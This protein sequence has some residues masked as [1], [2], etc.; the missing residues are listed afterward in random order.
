MRP[1][2]GSSTPPL[3]VAGALSFICPL[4]NP[5]TNRWRRRNYLA[6]KIIVRG[7]RE[8]NLK[9]VNVEIP[10][11]KL[12]VVTGLSGS[13]KSSL[14]FDTIYAEGQR[15]YVE[16]LSAYARQFLGQMK[17]PD[18][19]HIEGLSP[20]ISIDQKT[21]N[22]NPRSTVGT[23]TEIY[24]Y[25]RLMWAH[26]GKPHC[27]HCERDIGRMSVDQIVDEILK[28]PEGTKMMV[29]APV[30]DDRKGEYTRLFKDYLAEG[31]SRV[32]VD[33]EMGTLEQE[34]KLE[35]THKHTIEIV[36]DRLAANAEARDRLADAIETSFGLA[37]GR[38]TIWTD[39]EEQL[40]S[41]SFGC[42]EHGAV[43][44]ELA[45]RIFSFNSPHGACA[46]CSG[47]G[48]SLQPDVDRIIK[49]DS[50]SVEAGCFSHEVFIMKSWMGR[51]LRQVAK[52]HQIDLSTPWSK[53]PDAHKEVILY[54]TP[55]TMQIRVGNWSGESQWEGISTRLRR[56]LGES[57]SERARDRIQSFMSERNCHKC[58]GQRLKEAVLAV[59]VQGTNIIESTQWSI[60]EALVW[61]KGLQDTL[62]ARDM[63]IA[64]EVLKEVIARLTFLFDV[65]LGY[66]S[67]NRI[68]GTLSGGESQRIRLASQIGSGLQGVLYVLDEPSIGLHQRDNHRLIGTLK[69]LRDLDNTVLVVEHDEDTMLAA[70]YLIDIGPGAGEHGGQIMAAGTPKQVARSKKSLTGQYLAGTLKVELPEKRRKKTSKA[71]KIVGATHNNL[72]DVTVDIPIGLFT[73]VTGVSGSGK[74]T[75]INETLYKGTLKHLGLVGGDRPGAHKAIKGLDN[76]DKVIEID[77]SP[78]GRTPRSNP[79]TYTGLWT[80]IRE[81]FAQTLDA[82]ERGYKPGRFSFN[83]KGGRCESCEGDGV[84]KIEMHFLPDVFV[85][86]E[87]C[88]GARY[89]QETLQ[90]RYKNKNIKELLEMSVEDAL[91]FFENQPAIKRKLETIVDV[92][93]GYI[94]LGQPSTQLSGGEAQRVKLATELSKRGTGKTLYILDEPTTGL[95]VHDIKH[96]LGVLQR[97]TDQGN[98]V[99]VIE[100]NLDVI[101]CADWVIDIGPEGGDEGGKILAEGTP[102]QVAAVDVSYTGQF[103]KPLVTP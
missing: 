54:G 17:K 73:A 53:L 75:L 1:P 3:I 95:H 88:K 28:L 19:D 98:T 26:I 93:L 32:R 40:Y 29:L 44:T 46:Q 22:N 21:T 74:S 13:G 71:I 58:K 31:Y 100:H 56:L 34:W 80:P 25:L 47:I 6:D 41:A 55:E 66:L 65:G 7:A 38:V 20:A 68:S 102:E 89:N 2:P 94:R 67:M 81:L 63:G 78:I 60:K 37:D 30:V 77:Q 86:C 99:V 52:Q 70:D 27:P 62:D 84:V 39:K 9:G 4:H 36:I 11:G 51:W 85:P 33:G 57:Q 101:K 8:H 82:K 69:R 79:A 10:R 35:K 12:C 97:L 61:F 76:I 15:R 92:G 64:K 18:V 45:P 96:L 14:A 49:D 83:V 16:S 87:V 90:V 5:F 43:L 72:Q 91:K 23:V 48:A 42:P 103:L 59:T 24:D 50:K